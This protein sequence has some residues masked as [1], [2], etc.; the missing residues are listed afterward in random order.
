MH[1]FLP[2]PFSLSSH[3]LYVPSLCQIFS[4]SV[5]FFV[6]DTFSCIPTKREAVVTTSQLNVTYT[7]LNVPKLSRYV[8]LRQQV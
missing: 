1:S 7:E 3:T 5:W 4:I 2:H 8:K 6:T